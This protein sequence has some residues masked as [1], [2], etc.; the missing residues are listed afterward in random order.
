MAVDSPLNNEHCKCIDD[1]L[2]HIARTAELIRKCK[3]CGLDMGRAEQE[4]QAQLELATR[5]K[6]NFFPNRV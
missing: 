6:R 4:N 5:I 2:E 3:D 1:A